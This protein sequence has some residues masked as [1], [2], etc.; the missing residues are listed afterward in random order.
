M[1]YF[2]AFEI[3]FGVCW[4]ILK[5]FEILLGDSKVNK[6]SPKL[7]SYFT[8]FLKKIKNFPATLSKRL[9]KQN[10]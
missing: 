10:H 2:C 8:D 5:E 6:E 3:R 9:T 7:K 1:I 4:E